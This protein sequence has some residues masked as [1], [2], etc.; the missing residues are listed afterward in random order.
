MLV[1]MGLYAGELL[2]AA[3]AAALS[4]LGTCW[5]FICRWTCGCTY[6]VVVPSA[7]TPELLAEHTT[8]RRLRLSSLQMISAIS[9]GN[10]PMEVPP[11]FCTTQSFSNFDAP[12]VAFISRV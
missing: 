4:S 9:S 5:S 12:L 11:Y 2:F 7:L 8:A 1:T 10:L 3:S 6:L